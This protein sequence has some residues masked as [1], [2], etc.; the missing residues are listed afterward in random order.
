MLYMT[1][2]TNKGRKSVFRMSFS[3]FLISF[4]DFPSLIFFSV[5]PLTQPPTPTTHLSFLRSLS[6]PFPSPTLFERLPVPS[7][8]LPRLHVIRFVLRTEMS[9]FWI[10]RFPSPHS[11]LWTDKPVR[12]G[13][14]ALPHDGWV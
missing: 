7:P 2:G 11:W 5:S 3:P 14:A 9:L 6:P 13:A 8:C 1:L 4:L 12:D 10:F